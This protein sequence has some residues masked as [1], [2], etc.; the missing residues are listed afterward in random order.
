MSLKNGPKVTGLE[1]GVSINRKY[2]WVFRE[3]KLVVEELAP[4]QQEEIKWS[5]PVIQTFSQ[6]MATHSHEKQL[7]Q[8]RPATAQD[9]WP[10]GDQAKQKQQFQ[11]QQ[12]KERARDAQHR[13][14]PTQNPKNK[15]ALRKKG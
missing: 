5:Q 2:C 3:G 9:F 12:Y 14:G 4:N 15:S 7:P 11:F 8:S 6:F 10:A 1:Y 13:V